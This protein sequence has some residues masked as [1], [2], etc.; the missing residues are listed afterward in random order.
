MRPHVGT[1]GIQERCDQA[2][3]GRQSEG[4]SVRSDSRAGSPGIK[5]IDRQQNEADEKSSVEIRPQDHDRYQDAEGHDGPTSSIRLEQQEKREQ[6][7]WEQKKI[8]PK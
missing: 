5:G 3:P 1:R 8:A 7:A 6:E 2:G 4:D